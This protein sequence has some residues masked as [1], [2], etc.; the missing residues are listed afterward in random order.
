MKRIAALSEIEKRAVEQSAATG[1]MAAE[2]ANHWKEATDEE[3][4]RQHYY[5]T[6]ADAADR[7]FLL[8]YVPI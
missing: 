2:D 3:S 1:T 5:N 8:L 7:I 6:V 4:G